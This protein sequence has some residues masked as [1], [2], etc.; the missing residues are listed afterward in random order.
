MFNFKPDIMRSIAILFLVVAL[1]SCEKN[2]LQMPISN[3]TTVDS[4]F[5][6]TV[7]AEGAIA[8]AYYDCLSQGLPY[9][10]YWNAML[11]ENL[12]GGMNYGWAWTMSEGIVLN[13]LAAANTSEDMDGY[14]QNFVYIRQAWLVKENIDEVKDMSAAD[15]ATVKG[16]MLGLLA[17]RYEQMMIMYGGVPIIDHAL[18]PTDSLTIGRAPLQR[19]L[20]SVV[21]WCDQAIAVLPSVWPSQWT[22]RLTKTAAMA[23]KAKALL[24]AARPLFNSATPYLDLGANNNLICFGAA[25]PTRWQTA[26]DASEAEITEATG[27]GGLQI[28]NT[29]NPLDDYGTATGV[30]SNPEVILAWKN[31][32]NILFDGGNWANL[33]MNAFYNDRVWEAQGNVLTTNMLENYYKADGTD[34]T[35][36][37]VG[38][39]TA[40]TDYTTRMNQMEPRFQITFQPWEQDSKA[41]PGDV[42]WT[43]A[44]TFGGQ[45]F[46]CARVVKFY[47]KASGRAWFEFPLFRLASAY[48][49][50]AEAYNE[51]GQPANALA[52]LNVIHE[53]AGLPAVTTTDQ[54]TLRGIIQREWAVEFYDEQYRLHD[55]KFW[56]LPNIGN[57]II[58][59]PIRTFAFNN[60]G[61]VTQ[62]GNT[63]YN[64]NVLYTAFW[65]PKQY[66]NPF[67]TSEINKGYLVQ[68]PGY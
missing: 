10:N 5:S 38:T 67:P 60:G 65:A 1:S 23:I 27:N 54:A 12:D 62:T 35:W 22:G 34:Q 48:L 59:G 40:F 53:R 52:R 46:G 17:Y 47:Y 7:K 45:G 42:N 24:Y 50:S 4:V 25:D 2:F 63:N 8:N 33:P 56:K 41:N 57:G 20:D 64:D 30:P 49:S 39:V 36:P 16:E 68:N 19:V 37:S 3:T 43:N 14:A 51:L 31:I 28:I 66:L 11:Q 6:T 58:G 13:G 44:A 18:L 32:N 15:K 21:S 26:L 55:V 61:S 29:G 9:T